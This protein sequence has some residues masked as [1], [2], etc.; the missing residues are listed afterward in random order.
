MVGSVFSGDGSNRGSL[1][2]FAG[3]ALLWP[4]SSLS[5][6]CCNTD[7]LSLLISS[8]LIWFEGVKL[9]LIDHVVGEAHSAALPPLIVLEVTEERRI[10]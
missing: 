10:D 7:W 4:S 9:N 3:T 2:L 5:S 6:W 8:D 1:G